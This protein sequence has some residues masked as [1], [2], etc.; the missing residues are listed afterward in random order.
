MTSEDWEDP[1]C[2][3]E[4]WRLIAITS[5]VLKWSINPISNPK[6]RVI[7]TPTRDNIFIATKYETN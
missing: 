7:V 2:P 4:V 6:P 5:C 1:V 3:S